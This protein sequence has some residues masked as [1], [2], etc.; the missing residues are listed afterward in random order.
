MY[1][2]LNDTDIENQLVTLSANQTQPVTFEV[3]R[4]ITGDYNVNVQ[5]ITGKFTVKAAPTPTKPAIETPIPLPTTPAAT[6]ASPTPISE[7]PQ[8]T[9]YIIWLAIG[10]VVIIGLVMV[11]IIS[12]RKNSH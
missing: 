2:K 8:S 5:G 10:T 6:A 1:L 4:D 11:I 9:S 12:R 3:V 7:T